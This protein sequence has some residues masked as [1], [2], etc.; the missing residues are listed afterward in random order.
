LKTLILDIETE[1]TGSDIWKDNERIISV[2]IGDDSQ[3]E[4]YYADSKNP[5]T[6]LD[7]VKTRIESLISQGYL[8]A[9]YNM[10]FDTH[11]IKQFLKC[12]IPEE[13]ALEL[14]HMDR[15]NERLRSLGRRYLRLEEACVEFGIQVTHK[16][17]MNQKAEQYKVRPDI[18]DRAKKV[19]PKIAIKKGGTVEYAYNEAIKKIAGGYAIL[20]AYN[21]FVTNG[22][23]K[24]SLFYKYAI[25]DVI[26]EFQLFKAI[27]KS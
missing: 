8:L 7:K 3:Q 20:D 19:A 17:E 5:L 25:G 18:I 27:N 4:F 26:C 10:K 12:D 23:S 9:G 1:N 11:N 24:D 15:F 14:Y 2:Q 6:K 22:C 13:N 16:N 21:E